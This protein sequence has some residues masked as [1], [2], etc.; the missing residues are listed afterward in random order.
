MQAEQTFCKESKQRGLKRSSTGNQSCRKICCNKSSRIS[1]EE[2]RRE[3][4]MKDNER[5]TAISKQS[6]LVGNKSTD[7]MPLV[8]HL[9]VFVFAEWKPG[10]IGDWHQGVHCR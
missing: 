1:A 4:K 3:D 9:P 6:S 7:V 2:D 5:I 8:G 10:R